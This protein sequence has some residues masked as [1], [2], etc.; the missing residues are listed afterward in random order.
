MGIPKEELSNIFELFG[1]IGVLDRNGVKGNGI[2][3]STVKKLITKLE[4]EIE[5]SSTLGVGTTFEFYIKKK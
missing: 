5:V 4:G 3:L 2:G 1:T